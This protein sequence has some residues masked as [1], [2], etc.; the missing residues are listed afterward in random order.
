LLVGAAENDADGISGESL[1]SLSLEDELGDEKLENE[2]EI[3][4]L[5][6]WKLLKLFEAQALKDGAII[7]GL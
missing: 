3:A 1:I 2:N 7:S 4:I 5:G 6:G